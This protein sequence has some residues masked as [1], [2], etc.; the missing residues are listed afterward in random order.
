MYYETKSSFGK[1]LK[2]KTGT[3][4][5][6]RVTTIEIRQAVPP[7]LSVKHFADLNMIVVPPHL[8]VGVTKNLPEERI[9]KVERVHQQTVVSFQ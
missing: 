7:S 8:S 1:W 9:A 3:C 4:V 5:F 2:Q 6:D